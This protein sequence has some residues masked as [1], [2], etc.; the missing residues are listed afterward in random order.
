VPGWKCMCLERMYHCMCMYM[1]LR[2]R[3]CVCVRARAC[4]YIGTCGMQYVAVLSAASCAIADVE[5][6]KM[7]GEGI[8]VG[9]GGVIKLA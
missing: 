6:A 7:W 1:C 8:S 9:K 3:V 2:V 5:A 4:V